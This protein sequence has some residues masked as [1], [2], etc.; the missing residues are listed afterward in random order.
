M[1]GDAALQLWT[2]AAVDSSASCHSLGPK[3]PDSL[4]PGSCME[5]AYWSPSNWVAP[6]RTGDAVSRRD[7]IAVACSVRPDGTSSGCCWSGSSDAAVV[8]SQNSTA[9]GSRAAAVVAVICSASSDY[10]TSADLDIQAAGRG[11]K[12]GSGKIH[13]AN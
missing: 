4:D 5:V 2:V 10:C 9:T 11:E 8:V 7:G 3:W 12:E 6:G 13:L 1:D